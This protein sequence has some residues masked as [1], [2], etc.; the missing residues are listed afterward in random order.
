MICPTLPLTDC[1]RYYDV[2][3]DGDGRDNRRETYDDRR[4]IYSSSLQHRLYGQS[5]PRAGQTD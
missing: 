4:H 3:M 1:H 5:N 2:T